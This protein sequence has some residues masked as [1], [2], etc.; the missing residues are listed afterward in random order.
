MAANTT[1]SKTGSTTSD[2][3]T[4]LINGHQG[5]VQLAVAYNVGNGTSVALS[6]VEFLIPDLSTTVWYSIPA[7]DGSGSTLAAYTITLSATGNY[8][9]TYYY[10]PMNATKMRV[11]AS[12]TGGTTQTLQMDCYP[13]FN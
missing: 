12:Y 10:V 6:P 2:V 7:A 8:I 1:S 13:D 5:A 11:T 4:F 9:L 3:T